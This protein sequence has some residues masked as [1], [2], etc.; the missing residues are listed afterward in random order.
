[1]HRTLASLPLL[2]LTVV[3]PPAPAA[4]AGVAVDDAILLR[5]ARARSLPRRLAPPR[6]RL[7]E[8]V[9]SHFRH[10]EVAEGLAIFD[11][12]AA[13]YFQ[14]LTGDDVEPLILHLLRR[15]FLETRP[16]LLDLAERAAWLEDRAVVVE[17]HLDLL[18]EALRDDRRGHLPLVGGLEL[19]PL[20]PDPFGE[21]HRW[22]PARPTRR[23]AVREEIRLWGKRLVMAQEDAIASRVRLQGAVQ[24]ERDHVRTLSRAA[25]AMLDSAERALGPVR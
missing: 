1:M 24:A 18:E 12:F 10:D 8:R 3:G 15:G 16:V 9:V 21:P 22:L 23:Q 7:L 19:G 5:A 2:L 17:R 13:G 6:E 20:E 4:H 25:L 14:D 11:E